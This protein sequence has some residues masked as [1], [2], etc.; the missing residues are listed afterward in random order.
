MKPA[1]A[2]RLLGGYATG[3]LTETERKALFEAA[4]NHQAI[5]DALMDEE[6]L[7]ELL[8]DP[9]AKAQLLAALAAARPKPVP[10]WRHPG[11][12]GAAASLLVASLAGLAYLRNP[13]AEAPAARQE[14]TRPE[15]PPG[16]QGPTVPGS[17]PPVASAA[18]AVR[19]SGPSGPSPAE[20]PGVLAENATPEPAASATDALPTPRQVTALR[21]KTEGQDA[22]SQG[23]GSEPRSV[24]EAASLDRVGVV[25]GV[26][27]RRDAPIT[28]TPSPALAAEGKRLDRA[29]PLAKALTF[30]HWVLEPLG[31]GWTR[32]TVLVPAAAQP[33]LLQRGPGG[34]K[35]LTLQKQQ[36]S[37]DHLT[38]WQVQ[39]V[40]GPAD[41]LDLYLPNRP[42]AAPARLPASGPVDGFRMRIYP[43]Q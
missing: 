33:V 20:A 38:P 4:L 7:R 35:V 6:A 37:Q 42:V 10:F 16:P 31:E 2:E 24:P 30:P 39:V 40:L 32:V 5:F 29:E 11:L 21:A 17:R 3:T 25:G 22:V 8:S 26:A 9:E 18:R 1:K 19:A 14:S 23:T 27:P 15:P 34:V 36:R 13:K 12:L 41:V 43:T 28:A